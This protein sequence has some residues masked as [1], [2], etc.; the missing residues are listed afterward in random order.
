M[1][2]NPGKS[3][4]KSA[5]AKSPSG[6]GDMVFD[7]GKVKTIPAGVTHVVFKIDRCGDNQSATLGV[8]VYE[9]ASGADWTTLSKTTISNLPGIGDSAVVFVVKPG[10]NYAITFQGE[11]HSLWSGTDPLSLSLLVNGDGVGQPLDDF[12]GTQTVDARSC[13][14]RGRSCLANKAPA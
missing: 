10:A 8:M 1:P 4:S 12:G 9:Q 2:V 5:A 6:P 11:M 3:Q 7:S 14:V 13:V